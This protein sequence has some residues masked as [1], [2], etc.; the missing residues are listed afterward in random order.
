VADVRCLVRVD[1]GVLDQAEARAT[2]V[3]V[4]VPGDC[5]NGGG[6]IK[7]DIEI[8]GSRNPDR[9]YAF[10]KLGAKFGGEFHGDGTGRLT[11]ALSQFECNWQGEFPESDVWRLLDRELSEDDVVLGEQDGLDAGLERELNCADHS[12]I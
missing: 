6:A 11:E 8:A 7:A 3:G 10:W 9:S 2:D 1:A 4:P 12:C 5:A